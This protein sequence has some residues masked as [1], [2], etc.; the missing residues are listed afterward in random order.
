M[1]VKNGRFAFSLFFFFFLIMFSLSL[2]ISNIKNG[3]VKMQG[4]SA[5]AFGSSLAGHH[6]NSNWNDKWKADRFLFRRFLS[7]ASW[8]ITWDPD[9]LNISPG[10]I[11]KYNGDACYLDR[12]QTRGHLWSATL[13]PFRIRIGPV[14]LSFQAPVTLKSHPRSQSITLTLIASVAK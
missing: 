3:I 11:W 6:V 2:L 1:A 5:A 13:L 8:S 10:S 9:G 7:S 4:A 14:C 12:R